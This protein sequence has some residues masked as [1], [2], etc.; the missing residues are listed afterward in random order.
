MSEHS[1]QVA[2]KI[3]CAANE[4]R[5]P[6]LENFFAVPNAFKR[7]PRQGK[8]MKD[9]G[10]KA[11]VPDFFV[12]APVELARCVWYHGLAIEMKRPRNTAL[13]QQRGRSTAAQKQWL[14]RLRKCGYYATVCY[15]SMEAI[16]CINAYCQK[17]REGLEIEAWR[18]QVI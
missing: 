1:A 11:G 14:E 3:W 16:A 8:Y 13:K 15:G 18:K 5:F 17:D 4:W 12:L 6:E 2:V 9:E 7:T 10:L